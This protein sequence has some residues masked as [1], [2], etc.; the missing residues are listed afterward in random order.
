MMTDNGR[1]AMLRDI[2]ARRDGQALLMLAKAGDSLA[3]HNV[4]AHYTSGEYVLLPEDPLQAVYWWQQLVD[5]GDTDA[6]VELALMLVDN[7]HGLEDREQARRLLTI[8]AEAGN[9]DA[10]DIVLS[11]GW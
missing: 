11:E 10:A 5:A 8:A 7:R 1:E 3:M 2:L 6:M 9:P 4:A